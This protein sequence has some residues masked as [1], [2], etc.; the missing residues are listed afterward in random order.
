MKE[1]NLYKGRK[2]STKHAKHVLKVQPPKITN[3]L[4]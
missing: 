3:F 1:Q 4:I 2:T